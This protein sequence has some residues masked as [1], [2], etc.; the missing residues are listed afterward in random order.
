[1]NSIVN[2]SGTRKACLKKN[3]SVILA[4]F[5][6]VLSA[7]QVFGAYSFYEDWSNSPVGTLAN[8][9]PESCYSDEAYFEGLSCTWLA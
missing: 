5:L 4:V 2:N 1:M 9:C 3:V 6:A 8:S 7:T